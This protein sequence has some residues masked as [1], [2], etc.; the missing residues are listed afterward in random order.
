MEFF[1]GWVTD[2]IE[3]VS[4]WGIFLLMLLES[5]CI[6]I[7]SEITM[8]F[9]GFLAAQGKLN[10]MLVVLAGTAGNLVGSLIAYAFGWWGQGPI[11]RNSIRKWGKFV[12]ISEDDL[13]RSEAWFNKYGELIVFFSRVL[14]VVRT[15]ISVPAGISKMNIWK[16]ILYTT[17]GSFIWSFILTQFGA[18]LGEN[19]EVL[20]V[21]FRKFNFIIAGLFVVA[22][23]GYFYHKIKKLRA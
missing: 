5:A 3:T 14:P 8:P 20:E 21:Y 4:Y 11:V 17:L 6:P 2:F 15:F 12:L 19:W 9:G 10:F 7:P 23:M 16:F 22:A 13:D 18:T 1:F